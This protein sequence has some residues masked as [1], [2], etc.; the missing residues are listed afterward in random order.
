MHDYD[1]ILV[2]NYNGGGGWSDIFIRNSDWFGLLR[3]RA[4]RFV[5][6]EIYPRWITDHEHHDANWW[7]G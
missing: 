3:S 2:G 7:E 1:E 4:N 6:D 5:L